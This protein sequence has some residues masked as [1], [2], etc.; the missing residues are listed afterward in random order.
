MT[1]TLPSTRTTDFEIRAV[2][3]DER[4]SAYT[5]FME[6]LHEEPPDDEKWTLAARAYEPGRAYGAFAGDTL[7]G[8]TMSL[9]S[10]ITVP[11]GGVVP[12]AAVTGVGVRTDHRRRGVLTGLMRRQLADLA[13]A[14]EVFA[15]LHAS[16]PTIYGRFGY[17]LGTLARVVR[18]KPPRAR[19]RAD[20]PTAG[21]TRL[22]T[23]DEALTLLPGAYQRLRPRRAG[24]M[25][26][27]PSWWA[28]CYEYRLTH[29]RL[30]VAAHYGP[31][32]E[33]DGM[34]GFRSVEIPSD[35]P[36]VNAGVVVLDF[37]GANQAVENDLWRFLLGIDLVDDVTVYMRPLD[38]PLEAMLENAHAVRC[39]WD[40]ELW[41]RVVDVPAALAART[42]G[43]ADPV[44]VEVVDPILP[45]NSGR[46]LVG[47]HGADRTDAPAALT[48]GVEALGMVYFG[49]WR[50][51][52]L[53]GIGR[54]A[55]HDPAA[56]PAADRLFATD[57]PSWCGSLF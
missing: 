16:E 28:M 30:R 9:T 51:S 19:M 33:I 29:M 37:V 6:A 12:M 22:L 44:V 49:A 4:R 43:A 5:V 34:V 39:E 40:E 17:G 32:G 45:A 50:P 46:Y 26:R 23:K 15:T 20:V 57:E 8:A 13:A 31:D 48:L 38:E 56:L 2:E 25:G 54:L 47:P 3:D 55:V 53:A 7:V 10:D 18:V 42:Y 52:K 24:V 14:G 1:Q 21:T 41:V 35:D 36:R 11:G 27:A